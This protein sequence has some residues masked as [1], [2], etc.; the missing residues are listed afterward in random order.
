MER[1]RR[2][3]RVPA[4][5]PGRCRIDGDLRSDW[6]DCTLIDISVAGVGLEVFGAVPENLIG[7]RLAAEVHA[8]IGAS[9]SISLSGEVRNTSEGSE[10]GT[11][12]GMEYVDL[13]DTER[14]ILRVLELMQSSDSRGRRELLTGGGT[15][16]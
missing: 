8:P 5:W 11:R 1:R 12:V 4:G 16:R 2:V 6:R 3:P 7:Y 15:P 13:S 10:G 14:K 9:V